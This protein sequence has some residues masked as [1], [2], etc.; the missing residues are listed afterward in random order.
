MCAHVLEMKSHIDKLGMLGV[1]L[2]RKLD[3][4]LVLQSLPKSYIK[5]V[6]DYYMIDH[7]VTLIDL[8]YLLIVAESEMIWRTGN[9]NLIGISTSQTSMDIDIGNIR[10]PEKISL[11]KG[12][13]KA[14][15][16]I[17]LCSK[18]ICLLLLPRE[19]ALV[20]RLPYL[21]KVS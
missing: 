19:G 4:D 6:K 1:I 11:P 16:E 2:S 18:R 8:T 17:V 15:Y 10:S 14:K 9:A 21:P 12:K 3:V 13:G 7:N 5:F 20:A